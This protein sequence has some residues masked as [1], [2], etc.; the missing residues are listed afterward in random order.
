MGVTGENDLKWFF[1]RIASEQLNKL[2]PRI[3]ALSRLI[4][5]SNGYSSEKLDIQVH[6]EELWTPG[7]KERAEARYYQAQTDQVY[8]ENNVVLPEEVFLSR[9]KDKGR[10]SYDWTA[11]DIPTRKKMLKKLLEQL[12]N[13]GLTEVEQSETPE[14]ANA[15]STSSQDDNGQAGEKTTATE[16]KNLPPDD[17]EERGEDNSEGDK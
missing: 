13:G 10:W 17:G 2:E 6:F 11:A 4:L 14:N 15:G 8:I 5:Q 1:F 9:F 12:E 7:E 16:A 3:Q